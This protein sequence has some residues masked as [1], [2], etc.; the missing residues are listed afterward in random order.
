[1]Q[2]QL[3]GFVNAAAGVEQAAGIEA[4]AVQFDRAELLAQGRGD[5]RQHAVPR[6]ARPLQGQEERL[7]LHQAPEQNARVQLGPELGAEPRRDPGQVGHSD[8]QLAFVRRQARQH[9]IAEVGPHPRAAGTFVATGSAQQ[10]ANPCAPAAGLA[11]QLRARGRRDSGLELLDHGLELFAAERQLRGIQLE[12][13]AL[14]QQAP[15]PPGRSLAATDPELHRRRRA[16][17]LVEPV[18]ELGAALGR[19]IVQHQPGFATSRQVL[20]QGPGIPAMRGLVAQTSRQLEAEL[21]QRQRLP[22]QIEPDMLGAIQPPAQAGV[23]QQRLA[24]AGRRAEQTQPPRTGQQLA[25]QPLPSQIGEGLPRQAVHTVRNLNRRRKTLSHETLPAPS[26]RPGQVPA[27]IRARGHSPHPPFEVFARL[28]PADTRVPGAC[29]GLLPSA[30][31]L[32]DAPAN[33]IR[34]R[35]QTGRDRGRNRAFGQCAK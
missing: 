16:Q 9:L 17:Q 28:E 21:L 5:R 14:R 26:K 23:D 3:D 10:Q 27:S 20:Q 1:M 4:Q 30:T 32:P 2:G 33:G 12:Q 35:C 22:G 15:E 24:V 25:D 7:R 6:L 8:Q 34:K 13:L 18:V 19:K 29:G 31:P 11:P